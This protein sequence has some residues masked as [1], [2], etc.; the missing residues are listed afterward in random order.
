MRHRRSAQ[1]Q[2]GVTGIRL[3]DG[4]D[5]QAAQGI[6]CELVDFGIRHLNPLF[7]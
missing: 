5:C 2:P 3:L 7:Y 1:R 4:V 6:D